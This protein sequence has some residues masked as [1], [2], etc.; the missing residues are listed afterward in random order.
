MYLP[1][2]YIYIYIERERD[3]HYTVF[4]FN[5]YRSFLQGIQAAGSINLFNV[6]LYQLINGTLAVGLS[7]VGMT[8]A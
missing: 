2:I 7:S 3:T 5:G 1:Y 4:L 6:S 8:S